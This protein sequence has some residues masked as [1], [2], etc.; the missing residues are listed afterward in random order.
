MKNILKKRST[1]LLLV[2][3]IIAL[4]TVV[5]AVIT[6]T[7]TQTFKTNFTKKEYF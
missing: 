5:Y 3:S 2:L 6:F 1:T 4:A 7:S